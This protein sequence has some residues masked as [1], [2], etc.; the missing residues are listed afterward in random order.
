MTCG[1]IARFSSFASMSCWIAVKVLGRPHVPHLRTGSR[2]CRS[3]RPFELGTSRSCR[4]SRQRRPGMK[5]PPERDSNTEICRTS[6]TPTNTGG[7]ADLAG[8]ETSEERAGPS[9][10]LVRENCLADV[11]QSVGDDDF[12]GLGEKRRRRAAVNGAVRWVHRTGSCVHAATNA[13]A[14]ATAKARLLVFVRIRRHLT[15]RSSERRTT[16]SKTT[17]AG[18]GGSRRSLYLEHDHRARTRSALGTPNH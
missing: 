8:A 2:Y 16:K 10:H 1:S 17:F 18:A 13:D 12:A 15:L 7:R 14:V 4:A 5:R 9:I 6:P 11:Y 3:D